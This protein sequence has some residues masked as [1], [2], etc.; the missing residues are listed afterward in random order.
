MISKHLYPETLSKIH[1]ITVP[2]CIECKKI[3]DDV[4]PHFRNIMIAMWNP[5]KIVK[6]DRYEKMLRSLKECDGKRRYND[7]VQQIVRG[8]KPSDRDVI[9]PARD[10]RCNL[11]LRRIVRGLV[12]YHSLGTAIADDR[13]ICDVMRFQIPDAFKHE[14][15]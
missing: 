11:I 13:V 10:P 4:E 9:F 7:L 3:W 15:I 1:R 2:E 6:D 5:D 12:H 14:F 8:S